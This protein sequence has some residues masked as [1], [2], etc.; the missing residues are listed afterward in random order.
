MVLT[1]D[2]NFPALLSQPFFFSFHLS[3]SLKLLACFC[4]CCFLLL[5]R[6]SG[7]RGH[8]GAQSGL[9]KRRVNGVLESP[10]SDQSVGKRWRAERDAAGAWSLELARIVAA[11][12]SFPPVFHFL[13]L[14]MISS[15]AHPSSPDTASADRACG[16]YHLS[17]GIRIRRPQ[18]HV[19]RTTNR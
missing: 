3:F 11:S 7:R 1:C 10:F 17:R 16:P 18:E 19:V 14:R 8:L 2:C 5:P 4:F 15:S 12:T 9:S 6:R 13:C